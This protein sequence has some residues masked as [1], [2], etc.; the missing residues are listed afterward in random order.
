MSEKTFSQDDVNRI[1]QERLAREKETAAAE[2]AKREEELQRKELALYAKQTLTDK[3][4]PVELLDV[5]KLDD[6]EQFTK[7]IEVLEG[8]PLT[9]KR[10]TAF[11]PLIREQI[12][13]R[14]I[15]DGANPRVAPIMIDALDLGTVQHEDGTVQN[16]D[17]VAGAMKEK[18]TAFFGEIKVQGPKI[19]EGPPGIVGAPSMDKAVR[20]AMGL[21]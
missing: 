5:L 2:I 16:M 4:L 17:S 15:A 12:K 6:Q 3:G 18:Y 20:G 21:K 9:K 11:D 8:L 7:S 13:Q 14:L 19:Y 1:V 10:N